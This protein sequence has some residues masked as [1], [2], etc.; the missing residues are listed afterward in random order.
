MQ[1]FLVVQLRQDIYRFSMT[2]KSV[3]ILAILL[4][5]TRL[6]A[7]ATGQANTNPDSSDRSRPIS[8]R[9]AVGAGGVNR[10][11]VD[12]PSTSGPTDQ[13]N[14]EA[15]SFNYPP[16]HITVA[17][18]AQPR[19]PWPLQ[20]RIAWIAN[21]TLAFV[22]YVGI[23]LAVSTLRKIERQT[24]CVEAV[25]AA[26][27][28][29]AEAALLHAQAIVRSERPW[30]MITVEPSPA[31]ENSSTVV[32]TN[33]G[34][35]PARIVAIAD[36]VVS[37]IDEADLPQVPEY[38]VEEPDVSPAPIILLPGE[39]TAIRVFSRED[40]KQFCGTGEQLKRVEDWEEKIFVHG[41]VMYKDLIAPAEQET[42][43]TSWC[44]WYIYGQ[45]KSGLVT[46]GLPAFNVQT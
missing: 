44:C 28:D 30:V 2:L 31:M 1:E 5:A 41:R 11:A 37:A 12:A 6:Q 14:P 36:R 33:R 15:G 26:A 18:P 7:A 24:K 3:A 21:L 34:K 25:A 27:A 13:T 8:S 4:A 10:P 38:P 23:I 42:H 45:K 22:G 19:S 35:T 20:D 39:S 16:P 32:A 9:P 17:T 29:I 46:I 43:E 40:V